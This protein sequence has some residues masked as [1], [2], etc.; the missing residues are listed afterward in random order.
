MPDPAKLLGA[1]GQDPTDAE[2]LG[3]AKV[4]AMEAIRAIQSIMRSPKVERGAQTRLAAACKILDIAGVSAARWDES[5]GGEI[6]RFV[7]ELQKR[8]N[9]EVWQ[10]VLAVTEEIST[11][12][13]NTKGSA[14]NDYRS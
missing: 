7:R 8:L 10:Q 9:P 1:G 12:M 5:M 4:A 6:E 11:E 3:E 2:A 13:R 14:R